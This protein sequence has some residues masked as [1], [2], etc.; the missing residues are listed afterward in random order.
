M[1]LHY[2]SQVKLPPAIWTY[3]FKQ[4]KQIWLNSWKQ[5]PVHSGS[6]TDIVWDES[7]CTIHHC[8][9]FRDQSCVRRVTAHSNACQF[10]EILQ[11]MRCFPVD[12]LIWTSQWPWEWVTVFSFKM[13]SIKW[14]VQGTH[15]KSGDCLSRSL[16]LSIFPLVPVGG[17]GWRFRL[18]PPFSL[19]LWHHGQFTAH[20]VLKRCCH[21]LG[22]FWHYTW[23]I[24]LISEDL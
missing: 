17:R 5:C 8:S 10:H 14:L 12:H 18:L 11:L 21:S 20:W 3:G 2:L 6:I 4:A 16:L 15:L 22:E 13:Y 9:G 1:D 7:S 19:A 23:W 24:A